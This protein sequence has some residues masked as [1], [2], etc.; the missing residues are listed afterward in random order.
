[1]VGREAESR[2]CVMAAKRGTVGSASTCH[3]L[4]VLE[5]KRELKCKNCKCTGTHNK[6]TCTIVYKKFTE[7]CYDIYSQEYSSL[8]EH[9]QLNNSLQSIVDASKGYYQMETVHF[10]H[11][12]NN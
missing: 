9:S 8:K 12:A 10:E 2:A 3:D 11:L 7:L 6:L 5:R 1:M 4:V